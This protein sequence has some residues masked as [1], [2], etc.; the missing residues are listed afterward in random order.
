MDR[1]KLDQEVSIFVSLYKILISNEVLC[2]KA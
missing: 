1:S 2:F